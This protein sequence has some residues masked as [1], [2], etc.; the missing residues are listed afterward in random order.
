[1]HSALTHLDYVF[2]G[3]GYVDVTDTIDIEAFRASDR[4]EEFEPVK[5][6]VKKVLVKKVKESVKDET[7]KGTKHVVKD[8][9]MF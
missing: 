4:F 6:T 7:V 1:M 2:V 3:G 9:P 5:E 8:N